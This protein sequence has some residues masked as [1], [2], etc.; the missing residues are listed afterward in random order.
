MRKLLCLT[1]IIFVALSAA[2]AVAQEEVTVRWHRVVPETK[3]FAVLM[4]EPPLRIRRVIPFSEELKLTTPV[5]EVA[6]RGVLFSVLSIDKKEAMAAVKNSD[7]F[8]DALRHAIQHSSRAKDSELTFE[9]EVTL[10]NQTAKQYLV[11]AE[12]TEG[13]AQVYE[14]ATHYYVL[15]TLGARAS[16]LLA[17]NFFSSFTLDAKRA[18]DASDKVSI[19]QDF[20]QEPRAPEPLWPVDGLKSAVGGVGGPIGPVGPSTRTMPPTGQTPKTLDPNAISGG[21]LNGKA[22]SKPQPAYPPIA[23]AARA[24]GVVTVQVTVD[25]EGYVISARAVGGHPLLQQAA[26]QAARQARFS[27]TRLSGVPVKVMGVITYNFVLMDD[28]AEPPTRKY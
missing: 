4:P 20:S 6:H 13:T 26:V 27:P 18:R 5:Y 28:P 15:M 12:G 21:V 2:V 1:S 8:A 23:V 25:E 24:Q 16:E 19:K 11:R 3:A 22:V 9:Q 17:S 14:S 7:D 10:N